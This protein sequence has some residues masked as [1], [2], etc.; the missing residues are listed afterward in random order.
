MTIEFQ[1]PFCQTVLK[2]AD[3]KAGVR[4]N[5]PGCG[6]TITVPSPEH[7]AGQ[8][9]PSMAEVAA[10]EDDE[11][12]A[13]EPDQA[14]AESSASSGET[15]ACPMC[16]A[17][18]KAVAKRCRFCGETL[19]GERPEGMPT[20]IDAGEILS[21]AWEI[22][23]KRLGVVIGGCVIVHGIVLVLQFVEQLIQVVVMVAVGAAGPGGN[24][25]AN[26]PLILGLTY[27]AALVFG[28]LNFSASCYLHA[29]YYRLLLKVARGER[30]EI[31]DVFSGRPYFWPVFWAT[32]LYWLVVYLGLLF[33]IVPGVYLALMLWP[34]GYVIVDRNTGIGDSFRR[35]QELTAGNYMACFVLGL[36]AVGAQIVGILACC[37]G[38]IV[39]WPFMFLLFAV[40]YCRMSGQA[41]AST[42]RD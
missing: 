25:A 11:F 9:D 38:L 10:P 2:T 7:E 20:Q 19:T 24:A 12:A 23:K 8:I 30:E 13:V 16:G 40:A 18:I 6:E 34:F 37:V 41:I 28:I 17:T 22:Y 33:L 4:A 3:E 15:R 35:A 21:R 27:G 29:G 39:S 31:M 42:P 26:N 32:F 5:C 14:R 1:C 36:A